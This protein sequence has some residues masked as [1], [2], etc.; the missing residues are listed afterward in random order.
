MSIARTARSVIPQITALK[1]SSPPSDL[2]PP[3]GTP[4][5]LGT[6]LGSLMP[7]ASGFKS[8]APRASL[9]IARQEPSALTRAGKDLAVVPG[10]GNVLRG[11]GQA[12]DNGGGVGAMVAGGARGA[13]QTVERSVTGAVKSVAHGGLSPADMAMG[14]WAENVKKNDSPGWA[15]DVASLL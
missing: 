5:S 3:A 7:R 15:K 14:A 2:A 9:P 11:A 4:T 1:S 8:T 13:G 12:R 6:S 10:L